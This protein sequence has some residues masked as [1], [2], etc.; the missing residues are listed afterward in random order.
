MCL[1]IQCA[2]NLRTKMRCGID[3]NRAHSFLSRVVVRL[4]MITTSNPATLFS[5]ISLSGCHTGSA[6]MRNQFESPETEWPSKDIAKWWSFDFQLRTECCIF[7][8]SC[9][10]QPIPLTVHLA[11][12]FN[13]RVSTSAV[14]QLPGA[15]PLAYLQTAVRNDEV[16]TTPIPVRRCVKHT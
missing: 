2:L 16:C 11:L 8:K 7:I 12:H 15:C 1:H 5:L 13:L 10:P 4:E 6:G 3:V 9:L 14:P